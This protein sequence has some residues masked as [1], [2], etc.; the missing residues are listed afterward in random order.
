MNQRW[1]LAIYIL[2]NIFVS[3]CVTGGILYIY[4]RT[5]Q[6]ACSTTVNA[7]PLPDPSIENVQL[8][9]VSVTGVGVAASEIV[10][11]QNSGQVPV[12]L[13]GW[14]LQDDE[15]DVYA[16]PQLSLNPGAT[17]KVHTVSG[18][19]TAADLYWGRTQ[20]SWRSGEVAAIVNPQGEPQAFYR[21]P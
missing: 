20:A 6:A 8:E 13:T 1:R 3:V 21:I 10:V 9:I 4:D 5:D 7:Q 14:Y 16:F 12:Y 11:I 18:E 15:G 2:I 19:D 17:V